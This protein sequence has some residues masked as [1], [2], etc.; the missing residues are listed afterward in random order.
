LVARFKIYVKGKLLPVTEL[1]SVNI[2]FLKMI[3]RRLNFKL[4]LASVAFG[5]LSA[6][7]QDNGQEDKKM[8]N[9][10]KAQDDLLIKD[11]INGWWTASMRN[12]DK[13][14]Q[15]WKD[16][17]FGMFI[18]WGVYSLPGG[19]W[20]GEKVLGYSEHLMRIKKIP[21]AEYLTLS[22]S[23]NPTKFNA[24]TWV[25][26]AKDAGMN[27]LIITAK[28][29]DGFAMYDSK[30]SDFN[31]V[32]QSAWKHDP[33]KDL[34]IACKKYGVHFGFYYSH[35]FDWEHPDAPGNSWDYKYNGGDLQNGV[36]LD[37]TVLAK[38]RK[39]VDEKSI[40]QIKELILNYH[41][42]ILWFDTPQK[43]PFSE[44]LRI[45]K[46]IREIDTNVVIN[47]RLARGGKSV[48]GDYRN[49]GD[50]PAE[51]YPVTED[52]EAIPTTNESYGYSQHDSSHKSVQFFVQ[53][54]AKAA[55]RGGNLLL[56]VGPKGD[57][58]MDAR[59]LKILNGLS[60]WV[61][62]NK[63]AIYKTA[64]TPL[65]F[66]NFGVTTY[67]DN[68]LY[69]HVF[70]WPTDGKLVLGGLKSSYG[71]VYYLADAAKKSLATTL[72]NKE[73]LQ[74]NVGKQMPDTLNTVIVVE[75][76]AP[77]VADSVRLITPNC[78]TRL[79]AF[80]AELHGKGM[81]Y[82]DGKRDKFYVENW[83]NNSQWLSWNAR[84]N[85][86]ASYKVI[87]RFITNQDCEGAYTLTIGSTSLK[88]MVTKGDKNG[89][90]ATQDLGLVTLPNDPFSI[91]LKAE[92]IK[93]KELM[94][95]LEIQLIPNNYK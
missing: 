32:E 38:R 40:P 62:T 18:H 60:K 71:K 76:K 67:A 25:K 85:A 29:H 80:D 68:K 93:G 8:Y 70:N 49:T 30:V 46:A 24:D 77:I 2:T 21:R 26:T 43:L 69:L 89:E 95:I 41:P 61:A 45:L 87:I 11:A 9:D 65:A 55:S 33:M 84:N 27:Y 52:W 34:S 20:K 94:K 74:I 59:D 14:I 92:D 31:V 54:L 13:R 36:K 51:F 42:E 56:N 79:L 3:R 63:Q 47:G 15:W 17:K 19:Y 64:A 91:Q 12:H 6:A 16:A 10:L 66:Q 57:G 78:L 5:V 28:H 58:L 73:D 82:G 48:F 50:R 35:A 22:H 7:A 88:G 53:L 90:V 1:N 37:A 4:L 72:M 83:K 81:N 75:T 23:F 39:Y 86:K 44:N